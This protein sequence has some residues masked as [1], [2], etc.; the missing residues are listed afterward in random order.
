MKEAAL[1]FLAGLD[2]GSALQILAIASQV[3]LFLIFESQELE[4]V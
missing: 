3:A 1:P 4:S 2:F